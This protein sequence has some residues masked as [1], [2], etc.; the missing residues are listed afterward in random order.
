MDV[1][2]RILIIDDDAGMLQA[3]P[4]ILLRQIS[5]SKV[6]A[7]NS[8]TQGLERVAATDYDA[9]ISDIRMPGMDGL[10]LLS[11]IRNIRPNTPI[12]LMTA[13][14]DRELVLHALRGGAYDFVQ[15]PVNTDYVVVSLQRAIQMR[16]LSRQVAEQKTALERH[17]EE[18]ERSVERAVDEQKAAQRRLSFLAEASTLLASSLDYQTTLSRVARLAVLYLADVCI[19]DIT[20]EN[21]RL[22][23][24]AVAHINRAQEKLVKQLR[25]RYQASDDLQYPPLD[26]IRSGQ[27]ILHPEISDAMLNGFAL[28]KE[29]LRVFRELHPQTLMM[30]PL[31][32]GEKTLGVLTFGLIKGQRRYGPD[33]LALAE[34]LTRRAALAVDNARLYEEAQQAL[35]VRD[36]FLSIAAHELKTPMTSILGVAQLLLRH[37]ERENQ[38]DS[39]EKRRLKLLI[40]QTHRLNRLVASLLDL[41]RLEAGQLTIEQKSLDLSSLTR[42]L[43]D[44]LALSIETH[45]IEY[46]GSPQAVMV[47]GDEM[48]L[49]QVLQ[50]L[51]QNAIKYSPAGGKIELR[52]AEQDDQAVITVTDRGIG[53]PS[54]AIPYLFNRFYRADNPGAQQISG[55]GL[56]LY[57]V[58]QI[59]NLHEGSVTVVSTPGEGS[60]FTVRL[61]LLR[62]PIVLPAKIQEQPVR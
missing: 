40:E 62:Q 22:D 56:G 34:D 8:P 7:V 49:E 53:I 44:E 21:G 1:T 33:D 15:K 2:P 18:L 45:E 61:P 31:R 25:E 32:S 24:V 26:V 59:I 39:R 16:Q 17:A 11:K 35:Q 28:D 51:L 54:D 20:G 10:T 48:R 9:I 52:V 41:S 37:A 55:I 23:C 4:E 42:R 43:T 50:N 60:T 29:H 13:D 30:V 47:R 19:V 6:D 46:H 14:D 57:V 12:L 38:S 3:L 5:G 58:K 36:Q 27:A